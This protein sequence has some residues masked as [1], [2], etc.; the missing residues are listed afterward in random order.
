[1]TRSRHKAAF[2]LGLV[3]LAS[4]QLVWGAG[5]VDR[6]TG[7]VS[8][9]DTDARPRLV[10]VGDRVRQGETVVTGRDGELLMLTDDAGLLAV[11]PQ[12]RVLIERYRAEGSADDAAVLRLLRGGLRTVTGWIG[13]TA[14]RNHRVFTATAT[15]G[16]RGTDHEVEVVDE[17]AD[18]GTLG[19][20]TDGGVTLSNDGGS[21]DV[22][23]G[24]FAR[25]ISASAAPVLL[26][27]APAGAFAAATLDA[28]L[29][30]VKPQVERDAPAQL[31]EKQRSL[32]RSGG[33]SPQTPGLNAAPAGSRAPQIST[34][35]TP[36]S[37][38]QRVF[39]EVLRAYESGDVAT[40]Q[41][42]LDPSFI[43]YGNVIDAALRERQQQ[44]Q[45]R[46]FVLDRTMQCGP[47]VSVINFAWEKRYLA[48]AG[49]TPQ[50]QTGR[51]SL[52]IFGAG[53]EVSDNWRVTSISG[54][55]PFVAPAPVAVTPRPAAPL[56]PPPPLPP[57]PPPAPGPG[58]APA[59][60]PPPAPVPPPAP[61][62]AP[63]PP[64]PPP[65]PM[66][67]TFLVTPGSFSASSLPQN[68][69][70]APAPSTVAVA[71]N[72]N[73]GQGVSLPAGTLST[74][75]TCMASTGGPPSCGVTAPPGVTATAL[76][77]TLLSGPTCTGVPA[78]NSSIPFFSAN[79]A[80][81]STVNVP[82]GVPTIVTVNV[83]LSGSANG[84][85][86]APPQPTPPPATPF[87]VTATAVKACQIQVLAPPAPPPATV[88]SPTPATVPVNW[89]ITDPARGAVA[90]VPILVTTN[91]GDRQTF[92]ATPA[93]PGQFVFTS[94]PVT[95][96]A[97]SV[98]PENGRLELSGPG[99]IMLTYQ[100]ASGAPIMRTV[101]VSP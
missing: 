8:V 98:T 74:A 25:A 96:N 36:G 100:P 61:P 95:T 73:A 17:G 41:R 97:G 101:I 77:N 1:M 20:V 12:S 11:R 33:I 43:G 18:A 26:L 92:F 54:A 70:P 35:C 40:L 19:K 51:A 38:A 90:S 6:V 83:P 84:T 81:T 53:N 13:K 79:G 85:A 42:R 94:L 57:P 44:L 93:G 39:D 48:A 82:P 22:G 34:Q 58:G 65:A 78:N 55:S 10:A 16:I 46:I 50:L 67:A 2:A 32:R 30:Q 86:A 80:T 3:A 56:A 29:E 91:A 4:I 63:L 76:T 23:P 69:G 37:P 87:T 89:M 15:I 21:I 68:C 47:N 24:Q 28:R 88:C 7:D 45:T 9:L 60:P 72:V 62:P 59:P 5:T 71:L 52:L 64:V 66:P 14:P 27:Q 99:F 31:Q 49:L 75:G